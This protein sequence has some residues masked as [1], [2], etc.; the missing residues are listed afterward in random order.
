MIFIIFLVELSRVIAWRSYNFIPSSNCTRLKFSDPISIFSKLETFSKFF[1][2]ICTGVEYPC[3]LSPLRWSERILFANQLVHWNRLVLVR[4]ERFFLK[5][6]ALCILLVFLYGSG[7]LISS[8]GAWVF[9][10]LFRISSSIFGDHD[11][12]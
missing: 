12:D 1:W 10:W 5:F 4:S 9:E 8:L 7:V 2:F 11:L 3:R 6:R